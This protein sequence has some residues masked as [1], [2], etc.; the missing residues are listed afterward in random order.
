[1][2]HPNWFL[3]IGLGTGSVKAAVGSLQDVRLLKVV[4][5]GE[6]FCATIPRTR[7]SIRDFLLT[8][9]GT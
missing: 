2:T 4:P 9:L 8:D 7:N 5:S 1:M 6:G 3:G